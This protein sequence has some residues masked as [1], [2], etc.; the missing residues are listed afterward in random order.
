[1]QRNGIRLCLVSC[2]RK[3]TRQTPE[4]THVSESSCP[5]Q[6]SRPPSPQT[7]KTHR[8]EKT[9]AYT[10]RIVVVLAIV[11]RHYLV[12]VRGRALDLLAHWAAF[13]HTPIVRPWK[14]SPFD[15]LLPVLAPAISVGA[16]TTKKTNFAFDW[17]PSPKTAYIQPTQKQPQ[18]EN[19]YTFALSITH[20]R[21][22]QQTYP[23]SGS[24]AVR[25]P[26]ETAK[27]WAS[28]APA[29]PALAPAPT[30]PP[31]AGKCPTDAP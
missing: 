5:G 4:H 10:W 27:L 20:A 13:D 11:C 1:M 17:I 31:T 2:Y 6:R 25:Q 9:L 8:I 16:R 22:S 14:G 21:T 24:D 7:T 28:L 26:A 30:P 12:R 29:P 3:G 23:S 18:Q 15:A 19:A